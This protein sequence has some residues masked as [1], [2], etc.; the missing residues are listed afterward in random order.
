MRALTK[1]FFDGLLRP[2]T[3][4]GDDSFVKWLAQLMG[5]LIAAS[6]F[7]PAYTLP[8]RYAALHAQ[9]D[10]RVYE[11]AVR[12]DFLM[13]LCLLC[14]LTA[15]ISAVEWPM[16]FPGR[17]DHLVLSP[18]PITRRALFGAKLLAVLAFV[19]L[20][21]AATA[22]VIGVMLPAL[23]TGV[24]ESR[25]F[26]PRMG[27]HVAGAL[28]ACYSVF[29][30]LFGLQ[31][32]LA[33]VLPPRWFAAAS[34]GAQSLC[35]LAATCAL[36]LLPYLPARDMVDADALPTA[37]FLAITD[38][39]LG[40]PAPLAARGWFALAAAIALT[41]LTYTLAY[42]RFSQ[43]ALESPRRD[44]GPVI[45]WRSP[46]IGRFLLATL[47]RGRDQKLIWLL[48]GGLGVAMLA[49]NYMYLARRIDRYGWE[50][51]EPSVRGSVL[52]V[53]LILCYF[54]MV[55]LR[56]AFRLPIDTAANWIFRF[57]ETPERRRAWLDGS[58]RVLVGLGGVAVLALC[59]PAHLL[60]LGPVHGSLVA[61]WQLM[62]VIALGNWL[63]N[64]WN[65]VPFTA[66]HNSARRHFLHSVVAHLAMFVPFVFL[67]ATCLGEAL[68]DTWAALAT[69][70]VL[71][72]GVFLTRRARLTNWADEPLEFHESENAAVS[73]LRL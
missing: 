48:I 37:W 15:L 39:L 17:R 51:I 21:L 20:F 53:P 14:L 34:F 25:G 1:H 47:A 9:P 11:L 58:V 24:H 43:H 52:G 64:G 22:V 61:A 5:A 40:E 57:S 2:E 72:A 66:T 44:R 41:L 55:G 33:F 10:P 19:S 42:W 7:F 65:T 70:L 4:T 67:G 46:G 60:L 12:G 62:M 31:G 69:T 8:A 6:W 27:A 68:E 73:P 32:A 71:A 16:L 35:L 49:E 59:L 23:A 29:F 54:G 3:A 30:A 45:P 38:S 18:L 13:V 36:P 63:M 28:A 50:R 26:F 56:R